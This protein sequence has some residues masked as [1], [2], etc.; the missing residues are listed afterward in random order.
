MLKGLFFIG[1]LSFIS[2]QTLAQKLPKKF[3]ELKVGMSYVDVKKVVGDPIKIESFITV[4]NSTSDTTYYWR[5]QNDITL[6]ITNYALEAVEPKWETVLKKIQMSANLK[7]EN[8]ITI[9]RIEE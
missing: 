2:G 4:K 3:A 1:F 9:I 8:G 6:L 5:Y 7:N